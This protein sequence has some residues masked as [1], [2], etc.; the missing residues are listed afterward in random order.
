[1]YYRKHISHLKHPLLLYP[2]VLKRLN[3]LSGQRSSF[4]RYLSALF[5]KA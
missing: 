3:L 5:R 1:L 4:F 2:Q